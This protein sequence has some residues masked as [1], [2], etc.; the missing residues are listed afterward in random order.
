MSLSAAQQVPTQARQLK[1]LSQKPNPK[2][3]TKNAKLKKYL[4][5]SLA[6]A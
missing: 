1:T 6:K 4:L 2:Q 5:L 3:M